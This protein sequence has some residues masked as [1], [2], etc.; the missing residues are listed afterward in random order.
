MLVNRNPGIQNPNA[1]VVARLVP[2]TPVR[3]CF[4]ELVR[5]ERGAPMLDLAWQQALS[6]FVG[7]SSISTTGCMASLMVFRHGGRIGFLLPG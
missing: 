7:G 1:L 5:V 3:V 2:G 6:E 4:S